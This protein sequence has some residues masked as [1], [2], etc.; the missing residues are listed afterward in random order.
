MIFLHFVVIVLSESDIGKMI[1]YP[2]KLL[3]EYK[4]LS[5]VEDLDK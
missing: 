4:S 3:T 2:G 5:D 1:V